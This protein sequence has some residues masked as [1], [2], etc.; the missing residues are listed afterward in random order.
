MR[1]NQGSDERDGIVL[2]GFLV[3]YDGSVSLIS[4]VESDPPGVWDAQVIE[5]VRDLRYTDAKPGYREIVFR[6]SKQQ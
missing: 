3:N 1:I 2:V 4:I 6:F 5:R